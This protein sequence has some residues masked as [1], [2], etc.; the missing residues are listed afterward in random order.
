MST[1]RIIIHLPTTPTEPEDTYSLVTA[2]SHADKHT[3]THTRQLQQ[4]LTNILSPHKIPVELTGAE[5]IAIRD[6]NE[7]IP[8]LLQLISPVLSYFTTLT[9]LENNQLVWT[10]GDENSQFTTE[11][12]QFYAPWAS[13]RSIPSWIDHI[14]TNARSLASRNMG[15]DPRDFLIISDNTKDQHYIQC[16]FSPADNNYRVEM[17]VGDAQH[18]YWCIRDDAWSVIRELSTWMTTT[19]HSATGWN[20]LDIS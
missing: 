16:Y 4:Y 3:S 1:E 5:C 18:N 6:N 12:S 19:D 9:I 20:K 2:A 7:H 17:R 14:T 15:T 13:L 10:F 11:T 8:Q